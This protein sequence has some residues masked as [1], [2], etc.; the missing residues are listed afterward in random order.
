MCLIPVH[1]TFAESGLLKELTDSVMDTSGVTYE[2]PVRENACM[3]T[4][5]HS[6]WNQLLARIAVYRRLSRLPYRPLFM[7]VEPTNLC[8]LACPLCPTGDGS[9]R[10]PRGFMDYDSYCRLIDELSPTLKLL[11]L[12]GF[13]E[14]LLHPKIWNMVRHAAD[15]KIFTKISTNGQFFP[16]QNAADATI[17]SGLSWMRISLDG[18]SQETLSQYRINAKFEKIIEGIRFLQEAK[19]KS[20]SQTP[21]IE[22]QFIVMQHNQHEILLMQELARKLGVHYRQKSASISLENTE[23]LQTFLPSTPYS[24]YQPIETRHEKELHA[25]LKSRLPS[26]CAYPWLWAHICWDGAVVPCCKDPHRQHLLGN[27]F[28]KEGF[29]TVWNSKLYRKFRRKYL[30]NPHSLTRCRKCDKPGTIPWQRS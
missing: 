11:Q 26:V 27:A 16:D 14:P 12:W 10:A 5:F 20:N 1:N 29:L 23:T 24:R 4:Y 7:M 28:D 30:T 2:L 15:R 22:I 25:T 13:G 3:A 6:W 18:A 8:N 19:Q 17:E 9:L 21:Y